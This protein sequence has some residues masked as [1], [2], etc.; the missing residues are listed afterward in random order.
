MIT[1]NLFFLLLGPVPS[2]KSK[3]FYMKKQ[4]SVDS[5]TAGSESLW[6]MNFEGAWEM[7]NDLVS[8]MEAFKRNRSVSEGEAYTDGQFIKCGKRRHNNNCEDVVDFYNAACH[9]PTHDFMIPAVFA[10]PIDPVAQLKKKFECVKSLWDNDDDDVGG[11][12]W[13]P[14]PAAA[15]QQIAKTF[16]EDN[17]DFIKMHN[18]GTD[19]IWSNSGGADDS[20]VSGT[21]DDG[22]GNAREIYDN[23]K[24]YTVTAVE[25]FSP[26]TTVPQQTRQY[27]S[28]TNHSENSLFAEVIAKSKPVQQPPKSVNTVQANPGM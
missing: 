25:D 24:N 10:E 4:S 19:S 20:G 5:A 13:E 11:N 16:L 3:S 8:E 1:H 28:L 23:Y 15:P 18:A 26:T 2:S 6:D 17:L 27:V 9:F 22:W 14:I 7:G 21:V 12:V